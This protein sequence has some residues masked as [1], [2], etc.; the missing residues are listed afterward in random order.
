MQPVAAIEHEDLERRDAEIL[1]DPIDFADMAGIH[2]RKV[3]CIIN[4]KTSVGQ[5]QY[6]REKVQVAA[7]LVQ[8]VLA[9]AH[10]VE[11]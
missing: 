10:V 9:G 6:F 1:N 8:V 3:V 5:S 2:R 4:M 11:A 7:A